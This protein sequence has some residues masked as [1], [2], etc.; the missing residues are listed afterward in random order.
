MTPEDLRVWLDTAMNQ[1][2]ITPDSL[3]G[4]IMDGIPAGESVYIAPRLGVDF[5]EPWIITKSD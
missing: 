1:N 3:L 4:Q 2:E 5:I